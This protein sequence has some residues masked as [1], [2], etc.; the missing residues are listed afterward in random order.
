MKVYFIGAGPGDPELITVKGSKILAQADIVIYAGSLVS[1]EILSWCK[2]D[3]LIM[4]S[5]GMDLEQVCTVY[6]DNQEKEGIVA[7]VHTGDPSLFGAIQE[8]ME[9]L[10]KEKISYQIIPGVSSFQ[11]AAAA[12]E[13]EFTLPGVSQSLIISRVEG[14]TPVPASE[15][16][17][18]LAKSKATMALFLS[19]SFI[20]KVCEK[21]LTSYGKDTPT[22]VV[23]RASWP[24][25]KIL[26]G[27]LE[28]LPALV[29]ESGITRQA[30]II[31]GEV[32]N[33]N[34]EYSKL[35]DPAFSH[36]WREG[37]KDKKD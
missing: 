21:L 1:P 25:Q 34:F 7:R 35:Y 26:R 11:A 20:D 6:G 16:L 24:D 36:G 29:K 23:Y 30:L 14:R 28:N 22:A 8:Q 9:F 17:E 12:L 4:D 13:Q 10:R 31:V 37:R 32:L 19:I 33:Q 3:A 27:T 15:N 5:A 2:E 18:T